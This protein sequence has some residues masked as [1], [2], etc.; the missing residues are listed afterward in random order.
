MNN[1]QKVHIPYLLV[2]NYDALSTIVAESNLSEEFSVDKVKF[3]HI[4]SNV[5]AKR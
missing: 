1:V 2:K 3:P 4:Q 5:K